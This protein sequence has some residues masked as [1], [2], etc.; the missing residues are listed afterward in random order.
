MLVEGFLP[1]LVHNKRQPPH[2]RRATLPLARAIHCLS[3]LSRIAKRPM[4]HMRQQR[5]VGCLAFLLIFKRCTVPALHLDLILITSTPVLIRMRL[6]GCRAA[7]TRQVRYL[8]MRLTRLLRTEV[9]RTTRL[10]P[11]LPA[12]L[13]VQLT[14]VFDIHSLKALP[15]V[16]LRL[17]ITPE[18]LLS[19]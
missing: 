2:L 6:T 15:M 16:P 9:P 14:T 1:R 4:K 10:S 18:R 17:V 8:H 13:P 19:H 5:Q 11:S 7:G 12:L 3:T